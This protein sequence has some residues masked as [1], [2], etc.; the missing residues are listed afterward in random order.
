MKILKASAGSGK[1][2]RLS[3]QYLDLLLNSRDED[4][5]R[6]ILAVTFTNKATAEMKERILRNLFEESRSERPTAAK[7]RKILTSILHDYSAFSVCTIDKFFQQALKAFSREIGQFADYQIELDTASLVREAMDRLLDS[8]TEDSRELL[9]WIQSSVSEQLKKGERPNVEKSLYEIGGRLRSTEHDDLISRYGLD[10]S[11]MFSKERL[12]EIGSRCAEIRKGFED[13]VRALGIAV[14]PGAQAERPNKTYLKAHADA[15]ELFSSTEFVD[16]NTACII[17]KMIYSLGLAGEF[18]ASFQELVREKNVMCLDDSNKI[19]KDI[20]DGSDAPF[21]YEKL[22]VRYENFL[23]DEF[24]DTSN[25]Q[26]EN[27][28]PLLKESESRGGNNLVVG[29]VKQS[30]YR[31]RNSD[32]NLL[33][34]KV[35]EAF[36]LADEEAMENNWRSSREVVEFNNGF[37]KFAA[38]KLGLSDIYSDVRQYVKSGEEQGGCVRISFTGEQQ[39]TVLESVRSAYDAGARYGDIAV[40]VRGNKEGGKI[41]EFL[42]KNG[43]SVISDDSLE[44]RSSQT[45]RNLVSLL[46]GI[47]NPDDLVNGFISKS[48]EIVRPDRYHSLVDLCEDLLRSLQVS[49]PEQ[50][51]GELPFIQ[52][53]MDEIEN[54]VEQNGNN[55]RGFLAHWEESK[56]FI[57]SPEDPDAVRIITIH[58]SKGLEFPHVIFPYAEKVGLYK[59][60]EHWSRLEWNDMDGIYPVNLSSRTSDT[61]FN[62]AYQE[63]RRMQT[64]D[65]LNIFYVALTRAG[66]SLHIIAGNPSDKLRGA[67]AKN[68]EPE[69]KDMSQLLYAYAGQLSECR[70]GEPYDFHR[71]KRKEES[72]AEEFLSGYPSFPL[73]ERLKP[74]S[75]AQD[76]FGEDG[77]V[78]AGASARIEGIVLHGI[79][80]RV[81]VPE[82][83]ESS[84]DAAVADGLLPPEQG[85]AA[86]AMLEQMIS[87]HPQWFSEDAEVFAEQSVIGPDGAEHRPDRV[88][89]LKDGS[90]EVVDYKFGQHFSRYER[91]VREYVRLYKMLGYQDVRGYLWY[92][93]EDKVMKVLISDR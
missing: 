49:E 30:I 90:I 29:D 85:S 83:L 79:L 5:Y 12:K 82:D 24:Q 59:F 69:Y 28:R 22:G 16:Y 91:Q 78:G 45:V 74:S 10:D 36:P 14:K 21:I 76:F 9:G 23:L 84:V 47:D 11:V 37:F 51:A 71:M 6:H 2:Y 61:H 18:H 60:D 3:K 58:K 53:F 81:K 34:R 4:A 48:L 63:E 44:L 54:W 7:A 65:N 1:T 52:A 89:R 92:V 35:K 26:W 32:W 66:K 62:D 57:G 8:L 67:L 56:F 87:A 55:L 93:R 20:I 19:L 72:T 27:F 15:E 39:E 31:F 17:G 75:D 13:K 25:V 88:V 41:A 43:I 77:V 80:E 68:K 73:G 42:I 50:Y 70:Y 38:E 40:L 64:V 46:Y 86:L 33:G